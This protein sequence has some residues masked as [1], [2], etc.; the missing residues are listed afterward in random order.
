MKALRCEFFIC[1]INI[2]RLFF[3]PIKKTLSPWQGIL[4]RYRRRHA[5]RQNRHYSTENEIKIGFV[6][7]RCST[8]VLKRFLFIV[9]KAFTCRS[10][11]LYFIELL[12]P[13]FLSPI[14]Q[15]EKLVVTYMESLRSFLLL[16][17]LHF[18][19][20]TE[21]GNIK[22]PFPLKLTLKKKL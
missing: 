2:F 16:Y 19:H 18:N 9:P 6:G 21:R 20:V 12:V 13:F 3:S 4:L 5:L 14:F 1:S 17:S 11:V 7:F 10:M 22:V 15:T 8:K